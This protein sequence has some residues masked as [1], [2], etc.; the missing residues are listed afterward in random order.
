M[1]GIFQRKLPITRGAYCFQ[2]REFSNDNSIGM[3]SDFEF[4]SEKSLCSINDF[5]HTSEISLFVSSAKFKVAA[6]I[7]LSCR[8]SLSIYITVL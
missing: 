5:E 8:A 7:L 4:A 2:L 3:K 6:M 1:E